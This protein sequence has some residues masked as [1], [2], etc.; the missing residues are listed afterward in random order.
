MNT[1]RIVKCVHVSRGDY[2]KPLCRYG[3]DWWNL[4]SATETPF[5]TRVSMWRSTSKKMVSSCCK[6]LVFRL[7][8]FEMSGNSIEH[9]MLT[10]FL[11]MGILACDSMQ[12]QTLTV[13]L[14]T[15]M[16]IFPKKEN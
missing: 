13:C 4:W 7:K 8:T 2:H 16:N 14:V 3:M 10:R 1:F 5:S 11:G 6:R 15:E 12:C 9:A